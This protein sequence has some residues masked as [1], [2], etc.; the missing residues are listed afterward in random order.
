MPIENTPGSLLILRRFAGK[1]RFPVDMPERRTI[2]LKGMIA[3][4]I[5][6]FAGVTAVAILLYT[7]LK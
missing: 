6:F 7:L 4:L 5:C 3:L 2:S 1:L